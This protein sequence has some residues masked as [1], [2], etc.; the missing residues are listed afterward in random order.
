MVRLVHISDLHCGERAGARLG[1]A[2]AAIN[3]LQPDCVV[4]TGDIAHSGR[5]REFE[6]AA[7]F[8]GALKSPVVGAP[9]NHDAPVFNPLLRALA[10]FARFEALGLRKTWDSQCCL[11]SVRAFNSARA[12]QARPDWSQGVYGADDIFALSASFHERARYRLIAC[13]HPPHAPA[14]SPLLVKTLGAE[15]A[16]SLLVGHHVLLCG[17]LHRSADYLAFGRAHLEVSTAPTLASSRER[18]QPPGFRV[19]RFGQGRETQDWLWRD[20]RYTPQNQEAC[21]SSA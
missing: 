11:V 15:Q 17:H 21:A 9:G 16:L 14:P 5:R 19:M 2:I 13:H 6:T 1:A 18:G 3:A 12:I 7:A 10:P 4:V 20:G 8:L